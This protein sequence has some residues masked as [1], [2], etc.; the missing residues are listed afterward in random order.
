MVITQPAAE[1]DSASRTLFGVPV[2]AL[3]MEQ[4]VARCAEMVRA[5]V[6][7]HHVALNAGK[8]VLMNDQPL[9][10]EA[11]RRCDL[12]SPDGQ[13]IVW[14]SR[15]LGR[16]LPERVAG[17]DL[18]ERLLGEAERLGWPVYFL[19]AT[20]AVLASFE[21][22]ARA[23]YPALAIAGCH[24]GYF[25][26]DGAM[27]TAIAE[28]GARLLFV[29]M[30]S[31][32]KE[33]FIAQQADRLGPIFTMGVGGSFDVWAGL[34]RRAPVW[35]QR[36]GLEWFYRFLQE[37]RRMWRRYLVGNCRFALLVFREARSPRN[38]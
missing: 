19:G 32:R 6:S 7:A 9:L 37:P 14:A 13:S 34:T 21:R 30:P 31:P 3:S 36:A 8:V 28:S 25:D 16:R 11:I 4:T 1:S 17:I 5:G 12:V 29:A 22:V 23:R 33:F 24:H 10:L 27:A 15:L 38:A 35:M 18:M 26:D 2:K 20:P